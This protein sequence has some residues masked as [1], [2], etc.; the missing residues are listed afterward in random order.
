MKKSPAQALLAELVSQVLDEI[1]RRGAPADF[2]T[3]EWLD[4]TR[5]VIDGAIADVMKGVTGVPVPFQEAL[6]KLVREIVWEAWGITDKQLRPKA[7]VEKFWAA[8]TDEDRRRIF[9]S[10]LKYIALEMKR[11]K[12]KEAQLHVSLDALED[13]ERTAEDGPRGATGPIPSVSEN[14]E[15][16]LLKEQFHKALLGLPIQLAVIAYL[17]PGTRGNA[18]KLARYLDIPQKQMSRHLARIREHFQKNG[19]GS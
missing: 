19:L 6:D 10:G 3:R 9:Y 4:K 1:E 17:L 13:Q 15:A 8:E 14:P 16:G 7:W 12:K 5:G 18:S 2:V 11:Q